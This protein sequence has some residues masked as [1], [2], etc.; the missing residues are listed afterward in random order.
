[1]QVIAEN[2]KIGLKFGKQSFAEAI[3][4][5]IEEL[6]AAQAYLKTNGSA[7]M[8]EVSIFFIVFNFN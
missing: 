4:D 2:L 1:M 5:L 7:T 3:H 6:E 8:T